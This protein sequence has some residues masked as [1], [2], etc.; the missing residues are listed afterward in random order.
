M[1]EAE[2]RDARQKRERNK[3]IMLWNAGKSIEEIAKEIKN[4]VFY[5]RYYL[6]RFECIYGRD[7]VLKRKIPIDLPEA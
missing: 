4:T 3:T 2:K 7:A 6:K 5:V 1:T